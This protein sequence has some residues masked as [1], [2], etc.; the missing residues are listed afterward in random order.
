ML[1]CSLAGCAPLNKTELLPVL[2]QEEVCCVRL[3]QTHGWPSALDLGSHQD[4]WCTMQQVVGVGLATVRVYAV[5]TDTYQYLTRLGSIYL[6]SS[7]ALSPR[8][9]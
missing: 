9:L 1:G 2:S 7:L 3:M 4:A 5:C 8:V 6:G